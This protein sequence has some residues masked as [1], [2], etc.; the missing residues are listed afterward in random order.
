[1]ESK[2]KLDDYCDCEYCNQYLEQQNDGQF[3]Q[4]KIKQVAENVL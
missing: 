1:M 3:I 2:N 4:N